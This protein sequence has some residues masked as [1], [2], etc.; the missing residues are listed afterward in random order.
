MKMVHTM[1]IEKYFLRITLKNIIIKTDFH[2]CIHIYNFGQPI[3]LFRHY[4]FSSP[5]TSDTSS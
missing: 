2:S 5:G 4:A 3:K 1:L